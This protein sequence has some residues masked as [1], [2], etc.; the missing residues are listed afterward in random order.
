MYGQQIGR[1]WY[2]VPFTL[3]PVCI[4]GTAVFF[5]LYIY[6]WFMI[7]GIAKNEVKVWFGKKQDLD[8]TEFSVN[9]MHQSANRK[10]N[11]VMKLH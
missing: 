3:K 10:A 5:G 2:E 4:G 1:P 9:D 6:W 8:G 11:K 7:L